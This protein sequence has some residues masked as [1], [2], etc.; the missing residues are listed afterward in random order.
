MSRIDCI[1]GFPSG[2]SNIKEEGVRPARPIGR[3]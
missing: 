2:R 3:I 1:R